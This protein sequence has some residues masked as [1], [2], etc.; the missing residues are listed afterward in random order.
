MDDSRRAA[1][2]SRSLALGPYSPVWAAVPSVVGLVLALPAAVEAFG[3]GADTRTPGYLVPLLLALALL[4]G[5]YSLARLVQLA[6]MASRWDVRRQGGVPS[7]RLMG[8]HS[9]HATWAAGV[10]GSL[11]LTGALGVWSALDG[12]VSGL[13]PGTLLILVG[14]LVVVAA[15]V[16]SKRAERTWQHHVTHHDQMLKDERERRLADPLGRIRE[17]SRDSRPESDPSS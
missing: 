15:L 11:L 2:P 5:G 7:R 10:G 12:K 3:T 16:L 17:A 14:A 13:E 9:M 8:E 4:A 1:G 6:V